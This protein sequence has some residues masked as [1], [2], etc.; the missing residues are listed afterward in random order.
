MTTAHFSKKEL[1]LYDEFWLRYRKIT[2]TDI[3]CGPPVRR[4]P[5]LGR[6]CDRSVET[7]V[8]SIHEWVFR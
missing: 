8:L 5:S 2:Q 6:V 1:D 7:K 4:E 3:Y